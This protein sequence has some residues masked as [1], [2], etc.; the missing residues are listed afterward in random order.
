LYDAINFSPWPARLKNQ[1]LKNIARNIN[2]D[3]D[4]LIEKIQK[5]KSVAKNILEPTKSILMGNLGEIKI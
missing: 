4:V 2:R 3:I 5:E 1:L